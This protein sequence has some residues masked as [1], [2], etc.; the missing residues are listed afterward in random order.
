MP[1]RSYYCAEFKS[2]AYTDHNRGISGTLGMGRS[3]A[4]AHWDWEDRPV[5]VHEPS[6]DLPGALFGVSGMFVVVMF[7]CFKPG[8]FF[9]NALLSLCIS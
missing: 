6:I 2:S 7:L 8:I 1:C 9:V 4:I 5:L 3:S